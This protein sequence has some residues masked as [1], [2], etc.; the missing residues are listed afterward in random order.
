MPKL[1]DS[2][3][4]MADMRLIAIISLNP[5]VAAALARG[6]FELQEAAQGG[7]RPNRRLHRSRAFAN[8]VTKRAVRAG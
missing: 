7:R 5:I 3:L 4:T 6:D 8:E 2:K 1:S